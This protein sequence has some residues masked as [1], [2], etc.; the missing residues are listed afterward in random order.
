MHACDRLVE[1]AK[2][3]IASY[4][5]WS[6]VFPE[7]KLAWLFNRGPDLLS[8]RNKLNATQTTQ[9]SQSMTSDLMTSPEAA[10]YLRI[11]QGTLRRWVHNRKI[12]FVKMG[13]TV[14]FRKAHLERFISDK[15]REKHSKRL[16]MFPEN[17]P[18][19]ASQSGKAEAD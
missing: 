10:I 2:R 8:W 19:D 18:S 11:S 1:K 12:E 9:L 17:C 5:L 15:L 16:T 13:R 14:R 4:D 6:Q 7:W 3:S